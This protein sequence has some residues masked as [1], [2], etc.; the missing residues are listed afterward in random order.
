MDKSSYTL[1]A[2]KTKYDSFF[3]PAFSVKIEG[4]EL[5]SGEYA[6][7]RLEVELCADGSAGSC[8]F[9]VGSEYDREKEMWLDNLAKTIK[10]GARLEIKGGYVKTEPIFYG[11]VD[12]FTLDYSGHESPRISVSGM[13]GFGFLMNCQEPIYGGQKKPRQ[14]VEDILGKA[15]AAG[16]AKSKTVGALAESDVPPVKE[17]L[18][19]FKYLRML[20]ERYCMNLICVDGELVFDSVINSTS[21][22][23]TLSAFTDLLGFSKRMS[24]HGQVGSVTVWGRDV[25]QKFIQGTADKVSL[26]GEGKT[27]TQIAS[28]FAQAVRREYCEYVRTEDECKKLA[29]ARLNSLALDF[30]S[31]QG[32]CPGLPELIPG[33]YIKITDL[34]DDTAGSYF[35]SKVRHR[36]DTREGYVTFFEVKGAKG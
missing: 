18:D 25:N 36:F 14:V 31:G 16:V 8:H 26:G 1:T 11:Y 9:T 24:L 6:M 33:R 15:V 21:P 28:K 2:L 27:A 7:M 19:D 34:D 10:V 20:A 30:V 22:I 5:K 17:Q 32:I 35:I 29:Q 4:K 12:E 23:I 3:A 13:D